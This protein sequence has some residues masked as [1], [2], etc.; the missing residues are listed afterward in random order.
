MQD[1]LSYELRDF[2]MFSSETY[3]SLLTDIAA[4]YWP[5]ALMLAALVVAGLYMALRA[6]RSALLL[7]V[8][9]ASCLSSGYLFHYQLYGEIMLSAPFYAGLF[10][11]VAVQLFW[12][13]G[14]QARGPK[15]NSNARNRTALLLMAYA[16]VV[17]PFTGRLVGG[18][19]GYGLV[20]LGPDA[21]MMFV[22]ATLVFMRAPRWQYLLPAIWCTISVLTF[23]GL[24][25]AAYLPVAA[26]AVA[27]LFLGLRP[28]DRGQSQVSR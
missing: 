8:A 25:D 16:F 21:T 23:Y 24:E 26:F 7:L 14:A 13:I 10:A 12:M 5:L 22:L 4:R 1:L 9:T 27:T 15:G 17:H 11:L 28:F 19:P 2:L 6:G 3:R 18:A 20:G